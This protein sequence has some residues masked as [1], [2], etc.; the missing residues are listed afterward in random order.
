MVQN[1]YLVVLQG[2]GDT[3]IKIVDKE[4]F[5]WIN[6]D[7]DKETL[8]NGFSIDKS[9]PISVRLNKWQLEKEYLKKECNSFNDFYPI[10]TRGS[11][12]NDKAMF[13][14]G[15]INKETDKELIFYSIS[16]AL[17]YIKNNNINIVNTYEGMVY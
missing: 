17:K 10:V 7:I 3:Y 12:N 11:Y 13:T 15:I 9:C 2:Q 16:D 14:T 1:M 5:D 4:I 8:K 6:K